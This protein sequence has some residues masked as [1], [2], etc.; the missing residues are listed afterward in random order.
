MIW[1]CWYGYGRIEGRDVVLDVKLG[2]A[3][4]PEQVDTRLVVLWV[5]NLIEVVEGPMVIAVLAKDSKPEEPIWALEITSG[6]EGSRGWGSN[7]K[8]QWPVHRIV[9]ER[10]PRFEREEVL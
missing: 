10:R 4:L 9:F 3:G 6:D 8:G 2:G 1:S 7:I 5:Q